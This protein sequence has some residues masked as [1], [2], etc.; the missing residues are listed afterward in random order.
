[1][2]L[3]SNTTHMGYYNKLMK[4]A[5]VDRADDLRRQWD[6]FVS[7]IAAAAKENRPLINA[8]TTVRNINNLIGSVIDRA[9]WLENNLNGACMDA[10][11]L[12]SNYD[13]ITGNTVSEAIVAAER[14]GTWPAVRTLLEDAVRTSEYIHGSHNRETWTL[15]A[16]A[17]ARA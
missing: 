15:R 6:L 1:M 11:E 10:D 5:P 13:A 3:L 2:G 17:T 4:Q 14:D 9:E 16:I 8:A 7:E 12:Q